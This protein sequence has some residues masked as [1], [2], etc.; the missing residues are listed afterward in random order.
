MKK[1]IFIFMS[2]FL[3]ADTKIY[4]YPK[5]IAFVSQDK[6]IALENGIGYIENIPKNIIL[7]SI[8]FDKN[9]KSFYFKDKKLYIKTEKGDFLKTKIFYLTRG[10]SYKISYVGK[11]D[12]NLKLIGYCQ[13]YNN[14]NIFYKNVDLSFVAGEVNVISQ[15]PYYIYKN[16]KILSYESKPERIEGYYKYSFCWFQW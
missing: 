5:N 7:D 14:S 13:I 4:I 16:A 15:P 9:I 3:F 11:L 8:Y 1:M 6:N 12:K 2:I 10:I